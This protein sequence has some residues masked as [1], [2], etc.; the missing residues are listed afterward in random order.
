MPVMVVICDLGI[1]LD[2]QPRC[3]VG[4]TIHPRSFQPLGT[5]ILLG[6]VTAATE[7]LG[8]GGVSKPLGSPQ[9]VCCLGARGRS[10]TTRSEALHRRKG[11]GTP[12]VPNIFAV[13][14]TAPKRIAAPKS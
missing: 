1:R 10:D 9:I 4:H 2:A 3:V 7:T 6:A 5:A 14:V 8:T 13:A 11:L 12:P